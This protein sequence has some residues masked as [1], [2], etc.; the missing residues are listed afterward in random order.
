MFNTM[1][2]NIKNRVHI[3]FLCIYVV[4]MDRIDKHKAGKM[5]GA[6]WPIYL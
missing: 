4:F 1:L 6:I 3:L 2:N 5:I